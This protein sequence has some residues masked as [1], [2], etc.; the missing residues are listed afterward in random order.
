MSQVPGDFVNAEF[1]WQKLFALDW[2]Y[3]MNTVHEFFQCHVNYMVRHKEC[4]V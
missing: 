1:V 3:G 2:H 4:S